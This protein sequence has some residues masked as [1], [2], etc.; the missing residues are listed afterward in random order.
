MAKGKNFGRCGKCKK[1]L[2]YADSLKKI[3]CT[4]CKDWVY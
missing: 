4:S 1:F 2:S 3:T